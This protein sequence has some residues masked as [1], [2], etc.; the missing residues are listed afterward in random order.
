[1]LWIKWAAWQPLLFPPGTLSHYSNIGYDILGLIAARAGGKPVPELY[2]EQIF[3]PLG[4][5]AT[6]FD[7]Q[8]PIGGPH[9][10]GYGIEPDGTQIDTSDWHWGVGADGGIV[11]DAEDTATFLT[12]LMRGKLLDRGHLQR[13][14]A[15][16]SGAA[17]SRQAAPG[18]P[19][20]GAAA[21]AATRPRSGS[22]TAAGASPSSS[23]TPAT[24]TP[25]NLR[26]TSPPTPPSRRLYCDA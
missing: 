22:T 4:L 11:S 2:R 18:R 14:K 16:I 23:S 1:M 8:G 7:P 6:A 17:A 3:G 20:A 24:T 9:A 19:T 10:H 25:P 21:A 26:P 12:A 15:T 5:D 13:W